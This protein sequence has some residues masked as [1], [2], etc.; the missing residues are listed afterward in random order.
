VRGE[1]GGDGRAYVE[2]RWR[3][4]DEGA[5]SCGGRVGGRHT[6]ILKSDADR[7]SGTTV[8]TGTQSFQ[9]DDM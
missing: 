5:Q 4:V 7:V 1:I 3:S 8:E 9:K 6:Q 2:G